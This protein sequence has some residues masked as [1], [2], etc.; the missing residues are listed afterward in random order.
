MARSTGTTLITED[1]IP[2]GKI[3]GIS[4]REDIYDSEGLRN[5]VT[6]ATVKTFRNY[7]AYADT[8]SGLITKQEY[9]D[10]NLGGA[11]AG[12][13]PN[14]MVFIW[15]KWR[16]KLRSKNST[17]QTAA[18]TVFFEECRRFRQSTVKIVNFSQSK[19][20]TCQGDETVGFD[21]S[22]H[23]AHTNNASFVPTP[24]VGL[25][26]GRDVTINGLPREISSLQDFNIETTP[27]VV[28]SGA[29]GAVLL[30]P[31]VNIYLTENLGGVLTRGVAA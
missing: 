22:E 27:L 26:D 21:A 31:T 7:S 23:V 14:A 2:T 25:R 30:S 28:S 13:L 1:I 18:N 6:I 5:G 24:N 9:Q 8:N 20:I 17:M 19:Y 4:R 16:S 29:Q 3:T 15:Y 10:T 12:G 11:T